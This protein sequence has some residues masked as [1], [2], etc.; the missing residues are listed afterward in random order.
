MIVVKSATAQ[1]HRGG[2]AMGEKGSNALVG[3]EAMGRKE[4][5]SEG[6]LGGGGYAEWLEERRGAREG[7]RKA[8]RKGGM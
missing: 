7:G 3:Y 1:T 4:G 6:H 2:R 8:G 5:W